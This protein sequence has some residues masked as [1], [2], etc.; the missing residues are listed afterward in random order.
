MT[1]YMADSAIR[2][3]INTQPTHSVLLNMVN[4]L[5]NGIVKS[6]ALVGIHRGTKVAHQTIPP[7]VAQFG[8]PRNSV[9]P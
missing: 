3:S 6:L 2:Q 1:F 7:E 9:L 4:G 8:T 5:A